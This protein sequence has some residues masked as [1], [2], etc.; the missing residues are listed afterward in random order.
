MLQHL[1]SLASAACLALSLLAC[2]A[3]QQ[4]AATAQLPLPSTFEN[5]MIA[6]AAR[7]EAHGPCEP[8]ICVSPKDT[9]QVAAG[10][11]LD[12]QYW[13]SDGGRTWQSTRIKSSHGVYGDPVIVADWAGN[14]YFA[15]L[16]DPEG[17]GWSSA[18]LLDRIV[19]QKSTDGGKT[20]SDGAYVGAH[21]PKDQDKHW[22]CADPKT[23]Q[24]LCTWTEFD[25]YDSKD[26]AND[27]SRILFSKSAD[28]GLTWTDA[29]KINQFDGDCLDDDNTTEGAVPAFGPNGEMYVAWAWNNKIWFDRSTDGGSTWLQKDIVAALQPGG[30]TFDVP[31]IT[32]CNGMPVLVCDLSNGPH[33][34]TLYINWA[35]QRNGTHDTDIWVCKSTDGG[36]TWTQPLRV[37]DD[38]KGK[39]QFLT[40]MAVDQVTGYLYCVFYDRRDCADKQTDVYLAISRD[41]GASFQN[42]KISSSPFDPNSFVFFGDYNHIS[43]H[44]GIVRPIWTRMDKSVLSVWTA[45]IDLK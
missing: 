29:L 32:R 13:S 10:A 45:L 27:H 43:A 6:E 41:G 7:G 4:A 40:W 5:I 14:F 3:Q 28:G 18:K 12:R 8:S 22:L 11:I 20:Y 30:W 31:G 37:N 44:D 19:I 9:R 1:A 35:D 17:K 2:K 23:G 34:G 15:H 42:V 24:L 21:H 26:L 39:Q 36:N 38:R 33:R 16:S 25:K